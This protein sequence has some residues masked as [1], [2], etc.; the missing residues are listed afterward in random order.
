MLYSKI[1]KS[2]A[3]LFYKLFIFNWLYSIK[4][5]CRLL[6][7]ERVTVKVVQSPKWQMIRNTNI[8]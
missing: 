2:N 7:A 1:Q 3:G 8:L 4:E 5:G 6:V